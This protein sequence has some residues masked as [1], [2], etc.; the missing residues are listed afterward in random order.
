MALRLETCASRL[1]LCCNAVSCCTLLPEQ[2][3]AKTKHWL[4]NKL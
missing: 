1:D 4:L 3:I 2:H